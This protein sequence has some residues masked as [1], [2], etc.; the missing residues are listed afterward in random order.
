MLSVGK[1]AP[2]TGS[3]TLEAQSGGRRCSVLFK[4]LVWLHTGIRTQEEVNGKGRQSSIRRV[5]QYKPF[6][7]LVMGSL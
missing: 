4:G 2:G 7:L 3:N 1:T 5:M 6:M